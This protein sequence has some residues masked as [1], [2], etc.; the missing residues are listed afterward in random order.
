MI[1]KLHLAWGSNRGH[2]H[3]EPTT[4]SLDQR[5]RLYDFN[6]QSSDFVVYLIL[7]MTLDVKNH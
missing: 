7:D 2:S 4:L 3:S 6:V 1:K 5:A